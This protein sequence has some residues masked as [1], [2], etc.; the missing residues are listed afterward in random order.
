MGSEVHASDAQTG[1]AL[2]V[3]DYADGAGQRAVTSVALAGPQLGVSTHDGQLVGLDIDTG[4]T[5][6]AYAIGR[7]VVAEPVIARGWVYAPTKDG[8]VLALNVGDRSLAGWHLCGGNPAHTGP[9]VAP[10][11]SL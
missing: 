9:V 6:W 11:A 7:E 10:I 8:Y 2:W 3:R 4:Y 5:R 1:E